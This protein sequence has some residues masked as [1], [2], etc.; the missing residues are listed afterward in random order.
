MIQPYYPHQFSR[1]F[2]YPQDLPGGLPEIF[3]TRTLEAVY[4][5]W[6]SCTRL[7]TYSKVTIPDY[8][9]LEE[10]SITKAYADWWIRVCNPDKEILPATC[11]ESLPNSSWQIPLKSLENRMRKDDS[12]VSTKENVKG[13]VNNDFNDLLDDSRASSKRLMGGHQTNTSTHSKYKETIFNGGSTHCHKT[14]KQHNNTQGLYVSDNDSK[15]TSEC[16][17]KLR[18]IRPNLV[19]MMRPTLILLMQMPSLLM[20]QLLLNR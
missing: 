4:Q 6:E 11:I 15:N 20:S 5:H 8:H 19:T 7:G 3:C 10:F 18:K 16:H 9:S 2:G 13:N 17:F 1:K 14:F 12:S